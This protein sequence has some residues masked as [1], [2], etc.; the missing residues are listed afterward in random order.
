MARERDGTD[1]AFTYKYMIPKTR[2]ALRNRDAFESIAVPKRSVS[3]FRDAVGYRV[4]AG[5][6]YRYTNKGFVF[7]INQCMIGI[8]RKYRSIFY[9]SEFP[10]RVRS[11]T[12]DIFRARNTREGTVFK[13]VP[14]N[15]RN[16]FRK[17]DA[18]EGTAA[19]KRAIPNARN[20]FRECD[21]REGTA[22][23]K[24]IISNARD[25]FR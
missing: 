18:C 1:S 24:R 23:I 22:A 6:S 17:C 14:P 13:R 11:K 8:K 2:D 5:E 15:A 10:K 9:F 16:A 7:V 20:A 25:V 19:K 12:C 4:I 3:N 21:A